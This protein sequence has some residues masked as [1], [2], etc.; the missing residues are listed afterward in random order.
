[1]AWRLACCSRYFPL[2]VRLN[3]SSASLRRFVGVPA[4]CSHDF[5]SSGEEPSFHQGTAGRNHTGPVQYGPAQQGAGVFVRCLELQPSTVTASCSKL[6]QVAASCSMLQHVAAC[7]SMLQHVA[8]SCSVLQQVAVCCSKLQYVAVQ[9]GRRESAR[10]RAA[11]SSIPL[12]PLGESNTIRVTQSESHNPSHT[13]ESHN[14]SHT[15][16]VTQSESRRRAR[17]EARSHGNRK[18]ARSRS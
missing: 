5:V 16:R 17:H 15:I 12:A 11:T 14:P 18:V 10:T 13:S 7:C 9:H 2:A 8:A 6:Q 3:K 4:R 1:M